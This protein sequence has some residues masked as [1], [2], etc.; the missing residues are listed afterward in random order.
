MKKNILIALS[1]TALVGLSVD[2]VRLIKH[3]R[4][5]QNLLDDNLDLMNQA[6]KVL[7]D[8]AFEDIVNNM[9]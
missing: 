3:C 7:F 2:Y 5:I 8:K 6:Q 1:L 9:D 4:E